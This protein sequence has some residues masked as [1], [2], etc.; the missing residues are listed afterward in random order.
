MDC[1]IKKQF[2]NARHCCYT[3]YGDDEFTKWASVWRENSAVNPKTAEAYTKEIGVNIKERTHCRVLT[4]NT[5][6]I[7]VVCV[8]QTEYFCLIRYIS[9]PYKYL[10]SLQKLASQFLNALLFSKT[11]PSEDMASNPM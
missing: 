7:L 1:A 2:T 3:C 5:N 8:Q 6:S 10:S 11:K 9:I 4:H